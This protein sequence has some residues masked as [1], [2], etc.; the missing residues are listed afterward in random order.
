MEG[1]TVW[2][3]YKKAAG[4]K[5]LVVGNKA[6]VVVGVILVV[7]VG[8]MN[9]TNLLLLLGLHWCHLLLLHYLH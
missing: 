3:N 4:I 5:V 8:N 6:M 1:A 7:N 2:L 9:E